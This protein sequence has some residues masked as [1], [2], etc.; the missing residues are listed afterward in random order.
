MMSVLPCTYRELM[1][2]QLLGQL[3]VAVS[4]VHLCDDRV[5]GGML[6]VGLLG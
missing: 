5:W 1:T 6:G 4:S 2:V 3:C